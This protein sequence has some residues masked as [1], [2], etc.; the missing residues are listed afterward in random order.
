[1]VYAEAA[2]SCSSEQG[3][4]G[5]VMDFGADW[6]L[7]DSNSFLEH[8]APVPRRPARYSPISPS[9]A[10]RL[11]LRPGR[12]LQPKLT[13]RADPGPLHKPFCTSSLSSAP[14]SRQFIQEAHRMLPSPLFHANPAG[15]CVP[16]GRSLIAA[17]L[18]QQGV[19]ETR[20]EESADVVIAGCRSDRSVGALEI[21]SKNCQSS[22]S[23]RRDGG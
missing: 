12:R 4:G 13:L 22:H 18:S 9:T 16:A 21:Q 5:V 11:R 7:E 23:T 3:T 1:M 15:R 8:R 14:L 17:A 6:T 10:L 2:G 19:C 20:R